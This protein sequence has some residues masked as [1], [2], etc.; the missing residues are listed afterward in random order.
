MRATE[1]IT[2]EHEPTRIKLGNNDAAKAW[3][4]RVYTKYPALVEN[5]CKED[6]GQGQ[7]QKGR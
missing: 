7:D 3:I 5:A 4:D 6:K 1:F 2:E